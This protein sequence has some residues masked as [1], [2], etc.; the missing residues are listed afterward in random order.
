MVEESGF[1]Q[2][3]A[4]RLIRELIHTRREA[5]PEEVERIVERM[6]TVPFDKEDRRTP[7]KARSRGTYLGRRIGERT[8][9]LFAHLLRRVFED[10]QWKEGTTER[11]YLGDLRGAIRHPRAGVLL[12]ERQGGPIAAV[13]APNVVPEGRLGSLEEPMFRYVFRG[14]R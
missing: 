3:P 4:D 6:A 2:N 5:T 7:G 1:S 10:E 8:D 12:Y 11:Q 14:S 13:L 9:S